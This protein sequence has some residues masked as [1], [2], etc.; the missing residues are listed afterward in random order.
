[1]AKLVMIK[2]KKHI[3][4]CPNVIGETA[5]FSP[6]AAAHIKKHDGGE[7]VCEFDTE[8]HRFDQATQKA[9]KLSESKAA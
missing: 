8:T 4:G 7:V 2:L 3:S 1:M 6:D 5:G 9:V